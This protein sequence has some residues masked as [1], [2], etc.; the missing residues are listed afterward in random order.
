MP[1]LVDG[2]WLNI[3]C[4]NRSG[5]GCGCTHV[6]EL[7]LPG[8]V[9]EVTEVRQDGTV[10]AA[11]VYQLRRTRTWGLVRVDGKAWPLCQDLEKPDSEPGT[12]SVSYRRGLAVPPGGVRAVSVLAGEIAKQAAGQKCRLPSRVQTINREGV[13]MTLLDPQDWLEAGRTGLE[14]VDTWLG[15]VNPRGH[16]SRP[17]VWTPDLPQYFTTGGGL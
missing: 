9:H 4:C 2:A 16:R 7:L 10:L 12:L 14:E 5:A 6:S 17:L 8:P 11:T 1:A 13:T 15:Q 3:W